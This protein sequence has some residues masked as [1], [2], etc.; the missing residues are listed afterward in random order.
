[1][2]QGAPDPLCEARPGNDYETMSDSN[3][4]GG[5]KRGVLGTGRARKLDKTKDADATPPPTTR[6]MHRTGA[7]A[8]PR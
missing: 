8:C 4:K 7:E 3:S 1:M 2:T 5:E 6:T